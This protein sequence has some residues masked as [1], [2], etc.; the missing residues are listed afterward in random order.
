MFLIEWHCIYLAFVSIINIH[1]P[2]TD[3][4]SRVQQYDYENLTT[5]S[6]TYSLILQYVFY[7]ICESFMKFSLVKIDRTTLTLKFQ[8]IFNQNKHLSV[9][10]SL[11]KFE[12]KKWSQGK[13]PL[14]IFLNFL[15]NAQNRRFII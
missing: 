14:V 5:C 11:F 10:E 6:K 4:Q 1:P 3:H 12:N 13:M 15:K 7:R 9:L 8:I 2:K